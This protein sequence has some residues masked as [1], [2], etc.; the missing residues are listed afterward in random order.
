MPYPSCQ[1]CLGG[2]SDIAALTS[3]SSHDL[4]EA[5]TDL[6]PGQSWYDDVHG[7]IG[8]ICGWKTKQVYNYTVQLEWSNKVRKCI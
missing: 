7:E 6:V 8:D 4:C 5:I 3:T 2:L 1:G